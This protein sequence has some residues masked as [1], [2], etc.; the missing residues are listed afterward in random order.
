[1]LVAVGRQPEQPAGGHDL[2]GPGDELRVVPI[3]APRRAAGGR[4]RRWVDE[5]DVVALAIPGAPGQEAGLVAY[6][7]AVARRIDLRQAEVL[8][9]PGL[10]AIGRVDA[11]DPAGA[12]P[13]RRDAEGT[14]VR[15]QVEH[16]ATGD[17]ATEAAALLTHVGEQAG[18]E[19][20][21]RMDLER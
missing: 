12:G 8:P 10:D 2:G 16:R 11:G 7:E 13:G 4:E 9:R 5:D 17:Q 1:E 20:A 3:E 14:G 15:E 18:V 19:S 21:E 6:L